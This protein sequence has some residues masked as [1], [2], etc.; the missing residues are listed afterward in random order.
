MIVT[1]PGPASI[2]RCRA[3]PRRRFAEYKTDKYA[4]YI[5]DVFYYT[6]K[7]TPAV[8]FERGVFL[9]QELL[10]KGLAVRLYMPV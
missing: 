2:A 4:R 1:R 9:N 8:T 10:D 7:A 3:L 6:E 5:A